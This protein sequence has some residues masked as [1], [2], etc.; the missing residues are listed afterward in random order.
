MEDISSKFWSFNRSRDASLIRKQEIVWAGPFS[1]A[2]FEYTN[3]LGS[4]PDLA[5]VYLFA[6]EYQDGYILRSAGVTKSMKRRFKEH[7]C[8]Y[9]KGKYTILDIESAKRGERK[10]IWHG[11]EYAR[12]HRNEFIEHYALILKC[13]KE[14]LAAYRLFVTEIEDSRVRER[15]ESAIMLNA[16]A[17]TGPWSD[18]VDRGMALRGRFNDEVPIEVKNITPCKI[19]GLPEFLEI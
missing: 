4:L 3:K 17:S 6:F 10:E 9:E 8:E 15:I 19:Y 12:I 1:W 5:G 7:T 18:L 2:G 11:W 13:L 14:E 16:Y